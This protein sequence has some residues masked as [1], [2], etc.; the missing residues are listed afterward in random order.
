MTGVPAAPKSKYR[1]PGEN[2][3]G[4]VFM[5]SQGRGKAGLAKEVTS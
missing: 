2:S 3:T 5:N 4:R 1:D